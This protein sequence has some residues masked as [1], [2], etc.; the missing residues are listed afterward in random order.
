MAL[1]QVRRSIDEKVK[2]HLKRGVLRLI[3]QDRERDLSS[4]F[5]DE[6]QRDLIAKLIHVMLALG[7]YKEDFE[8][9]FLTETT[10]YFRDDSGAKLRSQD[11]AGYLH[12][13]DRTLQAE[14]HRIQ[15]CM[16]ISTKRMVLDIL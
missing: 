8:P 16:D 12:Y 10:A 5:Y 4:M 14:L 6:N 11:L 7:I 1:S 2:N 13:V 15:E 9:S 3:K